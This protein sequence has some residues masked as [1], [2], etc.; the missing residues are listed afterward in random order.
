MSL[1]RNLMDRVETY[2][3]QIV[4]AQEKLVAVPA[5]GPDNGGQGELARPSW[6]RIGCGRWV[7]K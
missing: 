1:A 6:W 3:D 5:L 4:E 7:W 2:A